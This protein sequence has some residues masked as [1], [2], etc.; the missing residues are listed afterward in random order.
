MND[1]Q[2]VADLR[3]EKARET[4]AHI[5]CLRRLRQLH[6]R[7]FTPRELASI[8]NDLETSIDN[9]L[10]RAPIDAPDVRPGSHGGTAYEIAAR[11]AAGEI[12]REVALRELIA[13]EYERPLPPPPPE[14]AWCNDGAPLVE[15]SFNIQIGSALQSGFL[16]DDDYEAIFDALVDDPEP[17]T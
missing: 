3:R 2:L 4:A 14:F 15:G 13:W 10:R 17:Q 1:E 7:G 5:A 6:E 9:L 8:T 12:D 11:Y 16:T